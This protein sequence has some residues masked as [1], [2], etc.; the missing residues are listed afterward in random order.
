MA[1]PAVSDHRNSV[2]RITL[3]TPQ[4]TP[5]P[6]I[7]KAGHSHETSHM[8]ALPIGAELR[9]IPGPGRMS[10]GLG[11]KLHA[12]SLLLQGEYTR[13]QSTRTYAGTQRFLPRVESRRGRKH[14][15]E[16]DPEGGMYQARPAPHLRHA[17]VE[18]AGR[19]GRLA[20]DISQAATCGRG[21]QTLYRPVQVLPAFA[22]CM[23]QG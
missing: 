19:P 21:V 4:D 12:A 17:G 18:G 14:S 16:S 22:L 3:T 11:G 7:G 20:R 6:S 15:A 5:N 23:H 10:R 9:L 1:S 8:P 13:R 2:S